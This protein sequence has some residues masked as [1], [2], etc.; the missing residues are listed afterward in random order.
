MART[1]KVVEDRREQIA[2]AAMRVFA[3]K[4][5]MRAT[6]KDIAKEAGITTGLIYHYYSSKEELL[7]AIV[8]LRSPSQLTRELSPQMLDMPTETLIRTL[9]L[10]MLA[11]VEGEQFVQ[12]L[13][14]FLPEAIHNPRLAALGLRSNQEATRFLADYLVAKM[15]S[16]ELR[17][18]DPSMAAQVLMSGIMGFVLRRQILNDPLA[19][20]YTHEQIVDSIVGTALHGLLSD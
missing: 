16:G 9:M 11:V 20:Q 17:K 3:Q 1:T 6:N 4:G 2:E 18:G 19:L 13:R 7:R 12:L 8:Q 14:V 10:Q 15:E 5:F